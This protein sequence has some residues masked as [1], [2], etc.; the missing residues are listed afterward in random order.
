MKIRNRNKTLTHTNFD[1]AHVRI[2]HLRLWPIAD[3]SVCPVQIVLLADTREMHI[4]VHISIELY[5]LCV[6]IVHGTKCI[7]R[8][9]CMEMCKHFHPK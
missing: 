5:V 2:L 3:P 8:I 7:F 1:V 4:L 6:P 9:F